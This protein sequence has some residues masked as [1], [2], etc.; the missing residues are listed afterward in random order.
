MRQ[1]LGNSCWLTK[2]NLQFWATQIFQPE[3]NPKKKNLCAKHPDFWF[4]EHVKSV[5]R[6]TIAF[7]DPHL[8]IWTKDLTWSSSLW[9]VTETDRWANISNSA[10]IDKCGLYSFKSA[11]DFKRVGF[12]ISEM[13]L[14]CLFSV[15]DF[16][17]I[18]VNIHLIFKLGFCSDMT[19]PKYFKRI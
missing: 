2:K 13:D 3:L 14:V 11:D 9:I 8:K 18:S 10:T 16:D 12:S 6:R 19:K 5:F 1:Y 4:T 7:K 17:N 15:N